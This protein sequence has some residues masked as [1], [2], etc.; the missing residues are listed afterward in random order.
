MKRFLAALTE[1]HAEFAQRDKQNGGA[2]FVQQP[3]GGSQQVFVSE[4][5]SVT[6]IVGKIGEFKRLFAIRS[7]ERQTAEIEM[8]HGLGIKAQP[9]AVV[10]A[11]FFDFVQQRLRH[12]A[13]AVIAHDHRARF[14][15]FFF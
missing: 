12:D 5:I 7:D 3:F 2:D 10:A 1:Q 4:R 13:L 8:V 9:H 14:G 11:E 15:D 6:C